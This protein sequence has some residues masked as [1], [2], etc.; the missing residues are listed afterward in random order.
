VRVVTRQSTD[1]VAIED[2]DV[3]AALTVIRKH[4]TDDLNVEMILDIVP[5][6]RR[7]LERKF[8]RL[9]GQSVLERIHQQR[10]EA[11]QELLA[12][13]DLPM[14]RVAAASG[15]SNARRLAVVFKAVT[16]QTPTEYRQRAQINGAES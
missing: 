12:E 3:S 5:V 13:T 2:P 1:T 4:L 11:A 6:S 8:R 16:G 14:P 15:F 7:V 9:L 10:V